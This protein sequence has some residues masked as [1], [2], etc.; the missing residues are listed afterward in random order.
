MIAALFDFDGTLYTG[1]IWQDL[2]GHHWHTRRHRHWVV[3]YLVRNMLP[4]PLYKL[5][6]QSEEAYFH[7][8][9]RT[10]GW[11][12]RGWTVEEAEHL[13][14]H[15]TQETILPNLRGDIL[16]CLR[17]H[18]ADGHLVA[19]VSGTF[20]PW[21]EQV[22]RA[23]GIDHTVG[24]PLEVRDGRYTGRIVPPVCQGEGKPQRARTYLAEKG[25]VVDWPASSAYADRD[26]DAPLLYQ[27]GHPTAVYPDEALLARARAEGWAV[28]G[29]VTS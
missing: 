24:T 8:W 1:H 6:M 20:A 3:A 11:L 29:E 25:L 19:L 2:V 22:A 5:G 7:T 13:F 15:L 28:M 23:L 27:V 10:M 17:E 18:Q 14:A 9:S 16:A 4:L 21:L 12:L 26:I